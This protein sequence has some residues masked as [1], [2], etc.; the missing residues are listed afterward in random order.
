MAGGGGSNI[1][2]LLHTSSELHYLR[3]DAPQLSSASLH[4]TCLKLS[5]KLNE[6]ECTRRNVQAIRIKKNAGWVGGGGAKEL[7]SMKNDEIIRGVLH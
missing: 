2:L 6:A 5:L 3:T 7:G 4:T 1:F